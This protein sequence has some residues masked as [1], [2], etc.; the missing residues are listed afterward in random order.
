MPNDDYQYDYNGIK[1]T[2]IFAITIGVISALFPLSVVFILCYRYNKLVKGK[3]L[4][5]YVGMIALSDTFTSITIAMGYPSSHSITCRVQG[6]LGIFFSRLSLFYTD[7]LIIKLYA[8]IRYRRYFL[9]NI[10]THAIIWTINIILQLLPYT[11]GG[12]YGEDDDYLNIPIVRCFI[13]SNGGIANAFRWDTYTIQTEQILSFCIVAFFTIMIVGYSNYIS[14]NESTNVML[15]ASIYDARS[16]CLYYPL[17]M[18]VAYVPSTT[19]AHYMDNYLIKHGHFP[20]HGQIITDCL[21]ASNSLYGLFLTIIFYTKT[22]LARAEWYYI[23]CSSSID[24]G[25]IS[26]HNNDLHVA[27]N[28]ISDD[29]INRKPLTHR[30]TIEE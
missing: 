14:R 15:I 9:S 7:A 16:T 23:I 13:R 28:P 21:L 26:D 19:Y 20:P 27:L 12:S 2:E 4:M 1:A 3:S 17:S 24:S 5:E 10:Y 30:T 6:F 22:K 25:Q 8:L 18:L 29:E 11:T